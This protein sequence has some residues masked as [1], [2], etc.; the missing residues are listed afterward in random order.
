MARGFIFVLVALACCSAFVAAKKEQE[1]W[2]QDPCEFKKCKKPVGSMC[3]VVEKKGRK[4]AECVCPEECDD[5][6]SPVCSVYGRQYDN[7]CK[8]HKLACKKGKYIRVAY[9]GKCIASQEPCQDYEYEQF[10][11]RLLEWF[12]H[13]KENDE[14]GSINPRST[15]RSLSM[16]EK[17]SLAEWKFDLLDRKGDKKLDRRD[18]RD[19]RYSLMPLEHCADDFFKGCDDNGNKKI[20]L[21]E[22]F[23][24]LNL[25]EE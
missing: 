6:D 15:T 25:D 19:F 23:E 8:L 4:T 20:T 7:R 2:E 9:E 13:L 24:C 11:R 3:Q 18:F 21:D 16:Q 17:R 14:F 22:W 5:E 12:L 1:T 10:P